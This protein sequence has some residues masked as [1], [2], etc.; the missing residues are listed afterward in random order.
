MT[1]DELNMAATVFKDSQKA[2]TPAVGKY[3]AVW[4]I[5]LIKYVL[6]L[7]SELYAV[8]AKLKEWR[9]AWKASQGETVKLMEKISH[10]ESRT[11]LAE[12]TIS[13]SWKYDKKFSDLI[14]RAEVAEKNL[15][16]RSAFALA[17]QKAAREYKARFEESE[18]GRKVFMEF[19]KSVHCN[20][21]PS[22]G[23]CED[24]CLKT[25]VDKALSKSG[26]VVLGEI[27]AKAKTEALTDFKIWVDSNRHRYSQRHGNPKGQ[28]FQAAVRKLSDDL[29]SKIAEARARGGK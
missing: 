1:D 28:G 26:A 17:C 22:R 9:V 7:R 10:Y 8:K 23:M 27:I 19:L 12:K 13:D 3:A 20:C 15:D 25:K 29:T 21:E 14:K 5:D 6:C 11:G 16:E 24:W 4:G 18:A 2:N